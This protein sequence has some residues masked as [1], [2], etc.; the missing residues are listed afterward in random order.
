MELSQVVQELQQLQT[1]TTLTACLQPIASF[2]GG[3]IDDLVPGIPIKVAIQNGVTF[4]FLPNPMFSLFSIPE[5]ELVEAVKAVMKGYMQTVMGVL[6]ELIDDAVEQL[7][8]PGLPTI[9][10]IPSDYSQLKDYILGLSGYSTLKEALLAGWFPVQNLFQG[11]SNPEVEIQNQ[12]S[13][14]MNDLLMLPL[15]IIVDFCNDVLSVLGFSFPLV[16]IDI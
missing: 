15:T 8:L 14:Y 9:P 13:A 11:I 3:A 2:L 10:T 1:M 5:I 4:P 6:I 7:E 16:C 12:L